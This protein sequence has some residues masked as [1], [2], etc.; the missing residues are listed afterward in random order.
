M[1]NHWLRYISNIH[2]KEIDLTLDRI[3]F[4]ANKLNI[5]P[6]SPFII[7]ISGTN[8][9]GT[10][11]RL[12]ELILLHRGMRVGVYNSPH[13]IHYK[14]RIRI[15]GK[16]VNN[17]I[18][19]KSF[20]II[21]YVRKLTLLSYFEFTTLSALY[22][23]SQFKLDVI[24]LEVGLGG[25]LDATN[26]VNANLAIITNIDLDHTKFL[27]LTRNDIAKE[28]SGIFRSN[29]VAVI[30]DSNIPVSIYETADA[31]G[32][33]LYNYKYDWW[34][35]YNNNYW[36]WQDHNIKLNNLP[37]PTSIP[38][39]NAAIAIAVINKLPFVIT[40]ENICYGL[41]NA[42]LPGRFNI[43]NVNPYII[44]DVAHNLHAV[45]YLVNLLKKLPIS[46]KIHVL[47][48][49]FRDKDFAKIINILN[50]L[51]DKWYCTNIDHYRSA[52]YIDLIKYTNMNSLS[53]SNIKD[54][55]YYMIN[56]INY[57]DVAV[58]LGSFITVSNIFKI[59]NN[60]TV[61]YDN[62][63]VSSK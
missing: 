48:G 25:R 1:I 5:L 57:N 60:K 19:I 42:W 38:I 41:I 3:S 23:F 59:I 54:A 37:I 8:G 44:L 14:E 15:N 17:L 56:S 43:I 62:I 63:L 10:T 4:V 6:L 32:T 28:K 35:I 53:F 40:R 7:T 39:K 2:Y 58:V 61:F 29:I 34:L 31:I 27:G 9:K 12:I 52:S 22:I 11:C 46:G 45:K 20:N 13:L 50:P 24:I 36:C 30:G 16:E 55:W 47:I 33:I 49:I 26:I 21:N 18:H 51:V